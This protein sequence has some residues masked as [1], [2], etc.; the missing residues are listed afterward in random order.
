MIPKKNQIDYSCTDLELYKAKAGVEYTVT[1]LTGSESQFQ[2]YKKINLKLN[3][4][5]KIENKNEDT[6]LAEI[7]IDG[8]KTSCS[9]MI[10]KNIF[11]EKHSN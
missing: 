4:K 5:I 7:A 8:K 2:Y 9:T 3:S 6:G 10:L 1:R 11:I